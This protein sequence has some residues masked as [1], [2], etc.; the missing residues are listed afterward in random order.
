MGT[1]LV[2]Y[3]SFQTDLFLFLFLFKSTYL[4]FCREPGSPGEILQGKPTSPFSLRYTCLLSERIKKN[5]FIH[6]LN[7]NIQYSPRI[8]G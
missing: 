4:T 1:F 3:D 5:T 6:I 7:W 2:L 8:V